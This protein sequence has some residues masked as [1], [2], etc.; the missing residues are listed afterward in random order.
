M[1]AETYIKYIVLWLSLPYIDLM[2]GNHDMVSKGYDRMI[3][4]VTIERFLCM[5]ILIFTLNLYSYRKAKLSILVLFIFLIVILIKSYLFSSAAK[6]AVVFLKIFL[7][8]FLP[9]HSDSLAW[10]AM[11]AFYVSMIWIVIDYVLKSKKNWSTI[12]YWKRFRF[13]KF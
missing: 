4:I 2:F 5:F 10:M 8:S 1:K 6:S 3:Y 7:N 13:G 11:S 9:Y 12:D